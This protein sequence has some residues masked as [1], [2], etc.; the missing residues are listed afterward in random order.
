MVSGLSTKF[1]RNKRAKDVPSCRCAVPRDFFPEVNNT[2]FTIF[3]CSN[4][5]KFI[6]NLAS[7]F[8]TTKFTNFNN[9]I[10]LCI[11]IY[12]QEYYYYKIQFFLQSPITFLSPLLNFSSS[13]FHEEA[14]AI[15][16][17]E[18]LAWKL[19]ASRK[20]GKEKKKG[21]RGREKEAE[22]PTQ[23]R[24]TRKLGSSISRRKEGSSGT[25]TADFY[26]CV[27]L[28]P[29]SFFRLFLGGSSPLRLLIFFICEPGRGI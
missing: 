18:K 7:F 25:R 2:F 29:L 8:L 23:I 24:E 19:P 22:I 16:E 17:E 1:V 9:C 14:R 11:N 5:T 10:S 20:I 13:D 4:E 21:E 12:F 26:F 6:Y 15:R 28:I 3:I 27:S